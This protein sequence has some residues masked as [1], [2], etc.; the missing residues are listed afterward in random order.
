MY[1]QPFLSSADYG[2]PAELAKPRTYEF[3]R[4]GEDVGDL[5]TTEGG[6][7]VY[8]QGAG[9]GQPR[10]F[11]PNR[12]FNLR[13]LRGNAVLRWEWRPGSTLYLAWQQDRSDYAPYV[14]DFS[15]ARDRRALFDA[16]PDNVLVLKVSYWLNPEGSAGVRKRAPWPMPR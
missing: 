12:D 15:M 1:A 8:P 7:F 4:Y 3:D 9:A 10:F 6:Y 5:E 16:Q 2:T 13:S 11:V 14:G